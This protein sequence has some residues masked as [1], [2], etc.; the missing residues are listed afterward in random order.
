MKWFV[1]YQIISGDFEGVGV[2]VVL[3]RR[4]RKRRTCR[5]V[6]VNGHSGSPERLNFE[7]RGNPR[8]ENR[9]RTSLQNKGDIW[10]WSCQVECWLWG[11]EEGEHNAED[12]ENAESAEK[13]RGRSLRVWA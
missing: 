6:L 4:R 11:A 3:R 13:R 10:V 7:C 5:A 2:G 9:G 8:G 12:A 1:L